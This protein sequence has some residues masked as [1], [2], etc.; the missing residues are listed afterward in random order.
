MSNNS[1]WGSRY[2]I[3]HGGCAANKSVYKNL[4]QFKD[5]LKTSTFTF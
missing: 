4:F 1:L 5:F 3:S 2:E